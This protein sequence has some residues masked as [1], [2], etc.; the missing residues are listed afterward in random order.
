M[1]IAIVDGLS[2]GKYLARELLAKGVDC[3][4]IFSRDDFPAFVLRTFESKNYVQDFGYIPNIERLVE[5]LQGLG[6]DRIVAGC[7]PGVELVDDL[8]ARLGLPGN[9][10]TTADSRRDKWA[11]ARHLKDSSLDYPHGMRISCTQE[12]VEWFLENKL[13]EAVIKPVRSAGADGVAY[14][15]DT[16][17][18]SEAVQA[19]VGQTNIFDE[20]NQGALIQE[21]LSGQEYIVNS[22]SVNGE[23]YIIESWEVHH[24]SDIN[25][26]VFSHHQLADASTSETRIL[27]AYVKKVLTA[28]GIRNAAGHSEVRFTPRGPVLLETG[29][30]LGGATTPDLV[31]K[32]TGMSQTSAFAQA[33]VHPESLRH[34][35][36]SA[37]GGAMPLRVVGLVNRFA[38]EVLSRGWEEQLRSLNTAVGLHAGI[39]PGEQAPLTRDLN[40]APGWIYLV[41][42]DQEAIDVDF[43]TIRRW[44]MQPFY[45]A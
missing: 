10:I 44:E 5:L 6:I 4:H 1:K 19:I 40:T 23:H 38:G 33:I 16:R 43:A 22:V 15:Q 42:E 8:N 26:P 28:L 12:A 32:F 21:N 39:E 17:E 35:D 41:S 24:V 31:K 18:V 25:T 34:L 20:L 14:C 2:T 3:Y 27:H 9:D 30:R 13:T 37:T 29:A 45:T 11:M 36:E 7:E